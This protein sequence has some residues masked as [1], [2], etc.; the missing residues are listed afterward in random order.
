[1]TTPVISIN[2]DRHQESRRW[3]C[4][5]CCI[6]GWI[7]VTLL[8]SLM[9]LGIAGY[10]MI[11]R[12]VRGL[13]AESP[14]IF[15]IIT[16][17]PEE[18]FNFT[19]QHLNFINCLES[20]DDV[21]KISMTKELIVPS[22]YLNGVI[23]DMD[24]SRGYAHV[25]MKSNELL[26]QTS[27]PMM[28]L[29]PGG[30]NRFFVVTVNI[31]TVVTSCQSRSPETAVISVSLDLG[32]TSNKDSKEGPMYLIEFESYFGPIVNQNQSNEY[33]YDWVMKILR[34][35]EFGRVVFC[36]KP[37]NMKH[38]TFLQ[39]FKMIIYGKLGEKKYNVWQPFY[40]DPQLL[41]TKDD[42][43]HR[44]IKVMNSIQSIRIEPDQ[45]VIR[46]RNPNYNCKKNAS[47]WSSG[48]SMLQQIFKLQ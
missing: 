1:M 29:I 9:G 47:V 40:D 41:I 37:Y 48:I 11:A 4:N 34:I 25:F 27:I 39:F 44:F 43:N 5:C 12:T 46:P 30:K 33:K 16:L 31:T 17:P 20:F 38:T 42:A 3:T 15:P 19:R 18:L 7:A 24:G 14:L 26:F 22:R 8:L 28:R 2:P 13:T 32:P 6:C 36:A 10:W 45:L 35:R 23:S 21:H